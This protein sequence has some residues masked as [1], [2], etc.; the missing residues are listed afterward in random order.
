VQTSVGIAA[1]QGE[2]PIASLNATNNLCSMREHYASP[3][4]DITD[5]VFTDVGWFLNGIGLTDLTASPTFI[6]FVEYPQGVFYPVLYGGSAAAVLPAGGQISN[7]PLSS[8][9]I[10]AGARFWEHTINTS[11]I[12]NVFGNITSPAFHTSIGISSSAYTY[13]GTPQHP[14]A[15]GSPNSF[16][17]SCITGTIKKA[18]ARG[19][20]IVGDSIAYGQGD[21]QSAGVKGASGFIAR[22]LDSRYPWTKITRGGMTAVQMA[23]LSANA[24]MVNFIA[25]TK[26]SHMINQFGGGDLRDG[27][28]YTAVLTAYQT[29]YGMFAGKKRY[30]ATITPRTASTDSW[31][32]VANQTALTDGTWVQEPTLNDVIRAGLANVDGYIETSDVS[33]TARNSRIWNAPPAWTVD[34]VHPL[35]YGAGQLATGAILPYS[36]APTP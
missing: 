35:S 4:G 22:G 7:D 10:A 1:N 31:A 13:A 33:S 23:A 16:G 21:Q 12:T 15:N 14:A 27:T 20:C 28:Q 17:A 8:V 18:K 26:A 2:L 5:L 36:F 29:I 25:A 34:G 32:T 6:K 30:Q 24:R 11:G 3:E 9:V 19:F